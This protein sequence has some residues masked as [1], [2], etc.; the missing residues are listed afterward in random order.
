MNREIKFRGKRI[1]DGEWIYGKFIKS[2]FDSHISIMVNTLTVDGITNEAI[3]CLAPRVIP[4]SVGEFTGTLDINGKEIYEG[5]MVTYGKDKPDEVIW[6]DSCFTLK[7][8]FSNFPIGDIPFIGEVV[9]NVYEHLAPTSNSF[10]TL[11][12]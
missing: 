5:D 7:R 9:G 4:E 11:N 3:Q 8:S 6:K 2:N 12:K 1:D 10:A